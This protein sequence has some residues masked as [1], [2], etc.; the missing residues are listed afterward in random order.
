MSPGGSITEGDN[1]NRRGGAGKL[2]GT[3]TTPNRQS[4]FG[5]DGGWNGVSDGLVMSD[6]SFVR[7][8]SEDGM[9]GSVR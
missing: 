3:M 7:M 2:D 9:K 1:V 8:G 5:K 4:V 6:K